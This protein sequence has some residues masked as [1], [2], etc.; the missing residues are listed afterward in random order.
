MVDTYHG[1]YYV[2]TVGDRFPE[3]CK[4]LSSAAWYLCRML[5]IRP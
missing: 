5:G 4:S 1:E 2:V 3:P